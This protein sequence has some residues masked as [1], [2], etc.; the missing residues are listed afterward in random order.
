MGLIYA[1]LLCS[2]P[3]GLCLGY[4]VTHYTHL[5]VWS[6]ARDE[7][8]LRVQAVEAQRQ[9]EL[10]VQQHEDADALALKERHVREQTGDAFSSSFKLH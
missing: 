7:R 2:R 10:L 6:G 1:A 8:A 4:L 9:R 5:D 3:L